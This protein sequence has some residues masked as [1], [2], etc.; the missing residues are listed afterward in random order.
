MTADWVI[1]TVRNIPFLNL[2]QQITSL[3]G[4]TGRQRAGPQ[5][6]RRG[7]DK[8]CST[9]FFKFSIAFL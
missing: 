8:Y 2:N 4:R 7:K 1:G 6:T 3:P 9:T 5:D